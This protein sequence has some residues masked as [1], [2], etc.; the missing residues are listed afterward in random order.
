MVMSKDDDSDEDDKPKKP[1]PRV[2]ELNLLLFV[3]RNIFFVLF[4]CY[5]YRVKRGGF[6]RV[7]FF[8]FRRSLGT[9]E[10]SGG[11]DSHEA[12]ALEDLGVGVRI[13]G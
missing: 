6:L 11:D 3:M 9:M 7:F 1:P 8:L 12:L 2:S 13:A 4:C 5:I 10:P